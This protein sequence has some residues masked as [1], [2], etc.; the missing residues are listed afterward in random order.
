MHRFF[1]PPSTLKAAQVL[2]SGE[3]AHQ[4]A[5]V[6]RMRSGDEVCLLDGE[7]WEYRVRLV[8]LDRDEITGEIQESKVGLGEPYYQVTIYL[9]LLNKA[10][11]F[12]WAL[13]KCTE[14]GAAGFVPIHSAR[15][16][17]DAPGSAKFERWQK[18]I[19]EAAEQSSRAIIPPLRETIDLGA[20]LKAQTGQFAIIPSPGAQTTL[21]SAL[22]AIKGKRKKSISIFIGPEGGFAPGEIEEAEAGGVRPI[23]LGPRTF[24]A[25]TAAVASLAMVLYE[26]GEIG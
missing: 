24:R 16:I 20:A 26:F 17:T 13:Q 4:I 6:L 3:A 19:R 21:K 1:V 7:G 25:E 14:I 22:E 12:E 10:D 11:K 15:S 8:S 23:T 2:I 5:R 18:I 9:S